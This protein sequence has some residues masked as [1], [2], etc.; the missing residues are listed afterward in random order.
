MPPDP[1]QITTMPALNQISDDILRE[2]W[3]DLGEQLAGLQP[4]K[5][6]ESIGR[7]AMTLGLIGHAIDADE[8]QTLRHFRLAATHLARALAKRAPPHES[9]HRG[10]HESELFLNVIGAFGDSE[11]WRLC[12]ALLPQQLRWPEH[13]QHQAHGR[14]LGLLVR[15]F[16]GNEPDDTDLR[17]V[18]SSCESPRASR[19]DRRFLRPSAQGLDAV[20]QQDDTA[21]KLALAQLVAAHAQE[22]LAGDLRLQFEGLACLR[23][24]MLARFAL[25][26]GLDVAIESPYLPLHLLE[27]D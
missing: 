1:D 24:L 11:A 5:Q 2:D 12:A 20:E 17:A 23:A 27:Q 10:P 16:A 6:D 9:E 4:K 3:A 7:V 8:A 13:A 18:L 19:E 14:Y 15:H 25:D 21:V 22:A 26:A